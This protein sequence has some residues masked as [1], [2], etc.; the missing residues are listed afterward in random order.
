MNRLVVFKW[1]SSI[2]RVRPDEI[3]E[4]NDLR[5]TDAI[6]VRNKY[7]ETVRIE[8][9]DA[10]A[11]TSAAAIQGLGRLTD[12]MIS[13][14]DDWTSTIDVV[15]WSYDNDGTWHRSEYNPS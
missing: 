13:D 7:G 3:L 12:Q 10:N 6:E 4:I 1:G 9:D 14:L 11:H 8:T 15:C 2:V 5:G